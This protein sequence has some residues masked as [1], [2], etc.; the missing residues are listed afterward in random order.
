LKDYTMAKGKNS[1]KETKKPKKEKPKISATANFHAS[2]PAIGA[3][4]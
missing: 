4:K 3:K 1:K 2:K